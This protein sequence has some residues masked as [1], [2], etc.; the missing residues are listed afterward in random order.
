MC[1]IYLNLRIAEPGKMLLYFTMISN[2]LVLGFYIVDLYLQL[3]KENYKNDKYYLF[4][5]MIIM[6]TLLFVVG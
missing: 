3:F 1:G 4:K 6:M 2:I 5:G